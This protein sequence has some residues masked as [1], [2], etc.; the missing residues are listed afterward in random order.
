MR[1]TLLT[2]SPDFMKEIAQVA[3]HLLRLFCRLIWLITKLLFRWLSQASL[4]L[5]RHRVQIIGYKYT[6]VIVLL[7]CSLWFMVSLKSRNTPNYLTEDWQQPVSYSPKPLDPILVREDR[8]FANNISD[9]KTSKRLI[10]SV[11][12]WLG[13]PH[14]DGGNTKSGTDC[15]G[16]VQAVA[17]ETYG[18]QLRRNAAEIYEYNTVSINRR[19]LQEGD[20]V[21]FSTDGSH[22]SHVGIYLKNN[23]FAHASTSKGVTI[24]SLNEPYYLK[25][26]YRAGR[27]KTINL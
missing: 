26:F 11:Y 1:A 13:T 9:S 12:S 2:P 18:I 10:N 7:A 20:L 24:S 21:F 17:K 25:T 8:G 5:Y 3:E 19:N 27:M 22:I 23:A 14:C 16:F 15:S 6:P 4:Y